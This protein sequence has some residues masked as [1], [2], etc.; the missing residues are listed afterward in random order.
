MIAATVWAKPFDLI[1]LT[2]FSGGLEIGQAGDAKFAIVRRRARGPD[3]RHTQHLQ[4]TGRHLGAQLLVELEL[5]GVEQFADLLGD[6]LA[7]AGNIKVQLA[8]CAQHRQRR[9]QID[10]RIAGA[11]ARG[12]NTSS[13]RTSMVSEIA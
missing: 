11:F 4:H 6:R 13:P 12:R 8:V 3:I 2:R 7:N 1:E 9:R 5:A 10:D